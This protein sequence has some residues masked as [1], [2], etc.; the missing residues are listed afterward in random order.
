M[1]ALLVLVPATTARPMIIPRPK[2]VKWGSTE[3]L[4]DRPLRIVTDRNPL[5]RGAAEAIIREVKALGGPTPVFSTHPAGKGPEVVLSEPKAVRNRKVP[6]NPEGY[7]LQVQP[8]SPSFIVGRT[9][10][11]TF[12]G[13]QTFC[14]LIHRTDHGLAIAACTIRDFPSLPWRGAHLFVGNTALPFHRRLIANVFS[15]FKLNRLVLQCEQAQWQTT[16]A[17]NP[18]WAMSKEDL[19]KEVAFARRHGLEPIPLISSL[20]HVRWLLHDKPFRDLREDPDQDYNIA[21]ANPR[22]YRLLFRLYDEALQTFHSHALHIGGD[23]LMYGGRYPFASK[24]KLKTVA[25]AFNYQVRSLHSYLSARGVKT[26]LWADMLVP[27]GEF[28]D[29]ANAPDAPQASQMRRGLPRDVQLVDWH[30]GIEK[31]VN[32]LTLFEQ[33]GFH[34]IIGA[35]WKW[36]S[37]IQQYSQ[38]VAARGHRGLLQTTWVGYNSQEKNLRSYPEAFSA[39]VIAAEEAW[40]GG[41][42]PIRSL[43]YDP[44][45]VFQAAYGLPIYR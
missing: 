39:F 21:A 10:Q 29:A 6:A 16:K 7:W 30:Y 34:N 8:G 45:K 43:G 27:H 24:A 37:A 36:P 20:G 40:N 11:A 44:R 28:P 17:V 13:A 15:R 42:R 35:T 33:A 2:A 31:D 41:A 19:G 14:Q 4:L 38:N 25:A 9:P 32:R 18:P 3:V 5:H 23:E 1:I 26:M 22:T 12:Y